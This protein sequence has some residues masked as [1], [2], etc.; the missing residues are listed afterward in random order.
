MKKLSILVNEFIEKG[1]FSTFYL[2]DLTFGTTEFHFTTLPY[3]ITVVNDII[4]PLYQANVIYSAESNL[5]NIDTPKSSSS[6]D[7]STF[8]IKF[9]DND[10]IFR[11][12]CNSATSNGKLKFRA[13]FINTMVDLSGNPISVTSSRG[14]VYQ[15]TMPILDPLDFILIYQGIVDK[16]TYFLSDDEGIIFELEC[17][18]PMAALDA[19]NSFYTTTQALAQRLPPTV[20]DTCFEDITLG[21]KTQELRWGRNTP[22]T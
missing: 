17:S 22:K 11:E 5:L 21:G 9:A 3:S 15:P 2:V 20:T 13:G 8:K 16:P 6:V 1:F 12:Y 10:F 4:R 7:K 19:T 18:S 14:T